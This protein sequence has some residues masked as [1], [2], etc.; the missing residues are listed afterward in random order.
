M[1]REQSIYIFIY[2]QWGQSCP[3]KLGNT[4]NK[5]EEMDKIYSKEKRDERIVNGIYILYYRHKGYMYSFLVLGLG[6][7]VRPPSECPSFEKKV[8]H[9][10]SYIFPLVARRFVSFCCAAGHKC[11]IRWLNHFVGRIQVGLDGHI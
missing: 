10:L 9:S 6:I 3:G 4:T 2:C 7:S 5:T 11:V 1:I 8:C